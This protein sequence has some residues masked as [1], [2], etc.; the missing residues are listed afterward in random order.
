MLHPLYKKE[1]VKKWPAIRVKSIVLCIA[2][3]Y[4]TFLPTA[5]PPRPFEQAD[6][7]QKSSKAWL[8]EWRKSQRLKSLFLLASEKDDANFRLLKSRYS[9]LLRER[10]W[11]CFFY[12]SLVLSHPRRMTRMQP[13]AEGDVRNNWMYVY[14]VRCFLSARFPFLAC[15]TG[16]VLQH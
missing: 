4:W 12:C 16:K 2:Q 9:C 5:I 6:P 3:K 15:S 14:H 8:I 13:A 10:E 7:H 1:T 11:L